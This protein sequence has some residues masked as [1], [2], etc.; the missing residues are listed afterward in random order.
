[1]FE[2]LV[3][4]HSDW[5]DLVHSR[6]SFWRVASMALAQERRSMTCA[7]K[8][9]GSSEA[10]QGREFTRGCLAIMAA[11]PWL[12]R[13]SGG[14]C[15][16][17]RGLC[18]WNLCQS[19][20]PISVHDHRKPCRSVHQHCFSDA[21]GDQFQALQ[22]SWKLRLD[23]IRR[24]GA[25]AIEIKVDLRYPPDSGDPISLF[26]ITTGSL[27]TSA[28]FSEVLRQLFSDH[29]PFAWQAV[30]WIKLS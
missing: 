27:H 5:Q 7:I 21:D 20:V 4:R 17:Q 29:H 22:P 13:R 24:R 28:T 9:L 16:S 26:W 3:V 12:S 2:D 1:M 15:L 8:G 6:W 23:R 25:P 11:E 18:G 14:D 10:N 30:L 19:H